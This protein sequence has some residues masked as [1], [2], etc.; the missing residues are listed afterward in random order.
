[1]TRVRLSWSN[2]VSWWRARQSCRSWT[3]HSWPPQPGQT[4]PLLLRNK[5][6]TY[7][8]SVTFDGSC[9]FFTVSTT[10]S[11][12]GTSN[13]CTWFESLSW[14]VIRAIDSCRHSLC[15]SQSNRNKAQ[16][17]LGVTSSPLTTAC[18]FLKINSPFCLTC[19][20]ASFFD[21]VRH[22]GVE[23]F[24]LLQLGPNPP[25]ASTSLTPGPVPTSPGL[26]ASTPALPLNQVSNA[27]LGHRRRLGD[28][29]LY[30]GHQ[31]LIR[32]GEREIHLDN[33]D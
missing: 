10:V 28:M 13:K 31:T 29:L 23:L 7:T 22:L 11:N 25:P 1:M 27:P 2:L 30:R 6:H 8:I 24:I 19:S 5:R 12:K 20:K 14:D 9:C 18:F 32:E 3:T 4:A 26:A 16:R 15:W 17:D 21:L 33:M